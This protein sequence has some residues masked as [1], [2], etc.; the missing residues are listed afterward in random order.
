MGNGFLLY[1]DHQKESRTEREE[2]RQHY[3]LFFSMGFPQREGRLENE[4]TLTL[5]W[6][7][8]SPRGS[9]D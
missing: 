8:C 3:F 9:Q 1:R 5:T 7:S 6:F 4:L 2:G